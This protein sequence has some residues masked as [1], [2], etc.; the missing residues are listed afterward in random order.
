MRFQEKVVIITGGAGGIGLITAQRFLQE[1]ARVALWDYS[2]EGLARASAKLEHGTDKL[3]AY[4]INVTDEHQVE[5]VFQQVEQD[6]GA[7]DIIICNAGITRDAMLHKM[8]VEAFDA[9]ID[10]NLKGVF[11]C[12]QAAAKRMRERGSGVILSTSSIVGIGGNIGQSN[13]AATKAGVIAMTQTWARELGSKGVRVNAV[14]PGFIETEMI[15]TVPDKVK[16]L[17][18][19]HTSMGRLGKPVEI[20]NAFIF[21]ASEEASFIT[22]QVLSVDG[23]LRL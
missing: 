3:R 12:G 7:V 17:V 15:Q 19:S 6:L 9:V 16:D 5:H 4:E 21:L 2:S 22:G 1:G 14:A 10:V 20:A 18:K 23:G 11:L 8:S 13:Y